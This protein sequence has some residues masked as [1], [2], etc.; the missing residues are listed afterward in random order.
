[1]SEIVVVGSMNM[2]FVFS[3]DRYPQ[4]GETII[5]NKFVVTP[6]GKG[7]NQA[8]AIGKLGGKVS[9]VSAC[10]NDIYGEQLLLNLE[11]M[12]VNVENVYRFENTSTGVAAITLEKNGENR[13]IVIPGANN[14]LSPAII[15][16]FRE[17]IIKAQVVLLQLE[18]PL[19]TVIKTIEIAHEY[20]I[21]VVVDPAPARELPEE[22]YQKIDYLLPNERELGQLCEKYNL[23]TEKD[24][25]NKL[26]DLGV[27][28]VL[29]TKG[30]QGATY[31]TKDEIVEQSAIETEAVDTTGAGDAFAGGFVF[32]LHKGWDVIKTIKF[33]ICVAGLSVKKQ[34]A[35][36]SL[37]TMDEVQE[38][39]SLMSDD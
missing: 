36:N 31:Y 18:I 2:D 20:Q 28:G 35:Q 8:A 25:I 24:K 9:F 16:K 10:G 3:A 37:P 15:D 38:V 19:E 6:G 21:K 33:A 30:R 22:I 11:K 12:G 4:Q 26:L 14:R 39:F 27:R 13:I 1:M 23:K 29:V 5:G 17:K 7:A 32:G 34:G